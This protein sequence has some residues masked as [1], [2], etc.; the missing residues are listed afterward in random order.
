MA[1]DSSKATL[2]VKRRLACEMVKYWEQ[3]QENLVNI[4]LMNGWGEKHRQYVKWKYVEA[5]AAAYY[6]HG[7]IL[8]E[9]KSHGMAAAALQVAVESLEESKKF[10]EAFDTT[11]P[12][13]RNPP[14]WGTAKYIFEKISKDASAKVRIN[15]DLYFQDKTTESAPALPD[16]A[17][18]LKPDEYQLPSM[19]SCWNEEKTDRSRLEANQPKGT[20]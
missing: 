18:A 9:G 11:P 7:L 3:A 20:R 5:K 12:L 19:H 14:L 1:I 15:R 17:L 13:S 2:A 16:F 6:F 8:D 4:P 10:S